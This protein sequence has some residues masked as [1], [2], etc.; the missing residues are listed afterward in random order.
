GLNDRRA[1]YEAQ[2]R[3][4]VD[5]RQGYHG[6]VAEVGDRSGNAEDPRVAAGGEGV[7][8]VQLGEQAHGARGRLAE[9]ADLA[10]GELGVAGLRIVLE[11]AGLALAGGHDAGGHLA[12]AGRDLAA[13]RIGGGALDAHEDVD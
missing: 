7:P 6:R 3:R 9:L 4:D 11:A 8:V 10:R 5:V 12:R 1:V 2:T 13:Q